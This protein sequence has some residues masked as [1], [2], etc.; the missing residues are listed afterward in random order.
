[1]EDKQ[2]LWNRY[3]LHIDLYQKYLEV[4]IKL[5]LFYYGITGAI[6]S[7]YFTQKA[8]NSTTE[9]VLVLPILFSAALFIFFLFASR[10]YAVSKTDIENLVDRLGMDYYVRTDALLYLFWGSIVFIGLT[11]SGLL[12]VFCSTKL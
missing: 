7:F 9:L 10:S 11:L 8:N 12:F 1:M 6:M 2:L 4:A 5:N 3:S